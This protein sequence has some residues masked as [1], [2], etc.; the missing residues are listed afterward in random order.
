VYLGSVEVLG[1]KAPPGGRNLDF[2]VFLLI[3]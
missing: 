3:E 1:E 2:P